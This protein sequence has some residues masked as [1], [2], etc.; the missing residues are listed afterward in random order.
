VV[1][2]PR[3]V[4]LLEDAKRIAPDDPAIASELGRVYLVSGAPEKALTEFGRA[5]ALSPNDP[6]AFT[7]RGVALLM[8]HQGDAARQ[9]FT[10][11]LSLNPCLAEARDNASRVGITLPPC[12]P[13][14]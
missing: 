14:R 2:P 4:A 10:R 1:D 12:E 13:T 6:R 7:N 9:D 5:L 3:A 8:M 11:A